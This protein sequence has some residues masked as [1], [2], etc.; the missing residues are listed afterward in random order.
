[1]PSS[2]LATLCAES[3]AGIADPLFPALTTARVVDPVSGARQA[4]AALLE[5]I[6]S[7]DDHRRLPA[8]LLPHQ[9]D[10]VTRARGILRR[11]GGVLVADGVGLGKTFI[12]LALAALEREDGGNAIVM[13]PSTVRSEWARAAARVEETIGIHS[14][15]ELSR[16]GVTLSG[17]CSLVIV[18][19][20]HA[21]R[22]PC[23]RRYASLARLAAGRRVALLTATPLNNTT[24]DLASLVRL[25]AGRDRFREFGVADIAD[26][27]RTGDPAASLALAA[28]SVSRTRR[29][30]E[31]RFPDLRAAFPVRRLCAPRQY[32][33]AACYGGRLHDLLGILEA[34]ATLP[35][36]RGSALLQLGLIRRL[37]SSRAALRRTLARHRDVLDEMRNA[38]SQGASVNRRTVRASFARG[39]ESQMSLWPLLLTND[40]GPPGWI[41]GASSAVLRA[42][43]LVDD[44]ASLPDTKAEQ[45]EALLESELS[46]HR[47]IVFTEH[48]DT[49][50][51]L[52]RRLRIRRRVMAV[53]GDSAWAGVTELSR[54]EALDAFAPQG[55]RAS[56]N[57]LLEAD[58]LVATDVASEGLNLQ[59]ASAVVNYDLPWNPVRVMQRIG[60]IERLY[61]PHREIRVA[62]LVP[63]EGLRGLAGVL[64]TL[65]EKLG[66]TSRTIGA[67]PDPLAA[68]WWL[69]RGSPAGESVERE[70]WR[71]VA[72]FEARERWRALSGP[73]VAR[74]RTGVVTAGLANDGEPASVGI[75][76]ALEWRGG[77]RIPLPYVATPGAMA[78]HDPEA[79]GALCERAL[80]SSP[81]PAETAQFHEVLASVMPMA[82]AALTS[83][84]ASRRGRP[85]P[86]SGR[87]YALEVIEQLAA[88]AHRERNDDRA[89]EGAFGLLAHD[90]PA[91]LD[92]MV[93]Q[94]SRSMKVPHE[95][96]A[97]LAELAPSMAS[98]AGPPLDG[99]PRL[100]LVAAILVASRCAAD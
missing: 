35:G 78:R 28:I 64:H 43:E 92:E 9:V 73:A 76:L 79:F 65:R 19:E 25:F 46:G 58:V 17:R 52:L 89:I 95:F 100:V 70:S 93:L 84:S 99:T 21:F 75:L 96:A 34:F 54:A 72:P 69:E 49:A 66:A 51:A 12:G 80:R 63:A 39:R 77:R 81:L 57:A 50:M 23:T 38:I 31:S 87:R 22:N 90:L 7:P 68:L 88:R 98:P 15:A 60:R 45:L 40:G 47:T 53:V 59:D 74:S 44:I 1:M 6:E 85:A 3:L 36:E 18:D 97:R 37:E 10:A 56:R 16:R 32:D 30:V 29:L 27:L 5:P 14:H 33:L 62:H 11:F 8:W 48:R 13:A 91:G 26:A 41:E 67:E 94:L 24:A 4:L 86:G 20:A 61:S 2:G 55:R 42:I 82:R 71:R 83:L